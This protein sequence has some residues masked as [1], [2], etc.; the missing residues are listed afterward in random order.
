MAPTAF[1][2]ITRWIAVVCAEQ[3][4]PRV[5]KKCKPYDAS[6]WEVVHKYKYYSTRCRFSCSPITY[7]NQVFSQVYKLFML[8]CENMCNLQH[9]FKRHVPSLYS[10][11]ECWFSA[12]DLKQN[13][14][15]VWYTHRFTQ[16]LEKCKFQTSKHKSYLICSMASKFTKD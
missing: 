6:S 12:S 16:T 5:G 13:R 10:S 7:K 8:Q 14:L 9:L 3:Q 1:Y 15:D 4:M 11:Q 2:D